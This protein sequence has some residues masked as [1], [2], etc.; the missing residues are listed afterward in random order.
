MRTG[1]HHFSS[2]NRG[3]IVYGAYRDAYICIN[4]CAHAYV[5]LVDE[6][7]LT[8]T[9]N[10][11]MPLLSAAKTTRSVRLRPSLVYMFIVDRSN[12]LSDGLI[13]IGC[14]PIIIQL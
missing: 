3:G 14:V 10:L 13:N 9:L 12:F 1:E 11:V 8:T 2:V 5:Q 4:L 7:L 6:Y